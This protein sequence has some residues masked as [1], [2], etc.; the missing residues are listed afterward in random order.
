MNAKEGLSRIG[1]LC[2]AAS[3]AMLLLGVV[4]SSVLLFGSKTDWG[5]FLVCA[6]VVCAFFCAMQ[7]TV[8]IL[9]GF[10]GN[11]AGQSNLFWPCRRYRRQVQAIGQAE[12]SAASVVADPVVDPVVGPAVA[13]RA[14][15]TVDSSANPGI[16]ALKAVANPDSHNYV[17][18]VA[19]GASPREGHVFAETYAEHQENV[20]RYRQ[21]A[22]EAAEQAE[23]EAEAVRQALEAEEAEEAPAQ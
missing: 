14:G 18:F 3:W 8:W 12:E 9:D 6:A 23:A 4:L 20:A 5:F 16:D 13:S 1:K 17:Y 21:I 22:R 19:K 11:K 10:A 2:S 7:G 15:L